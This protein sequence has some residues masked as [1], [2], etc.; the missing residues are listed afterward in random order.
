MIL[1]T[2]WRLLQRPARRGA[3]LWGLLAGLGFW[4]FGLTLVYSVPSG[5]L[6][7]AQGLRRRRPGLGRE[8]LLALGGGLLGASPWL[9]AVAQRGAQPFV[10]ELLGSAIAGASPG[11]WPLG[12][13]SH[14][15]NL[16]LFGPTVVLGMRPPWGTHSLAMPLLPL[17]AILWAFIA[18]HALR[19]LRRPSPP[20]RMQR[21]VLYVAVA[22]LAGYVLTPFGADPSGRYFVPLGLAL[23]VLAADF[24]L[25][26]RL[27]GRLDWL[28]RT[29]PALL[30]AFHLWGALQSALTYPPGLTTQ[31]DPISWIDKRADQELVEFLLA[32]GETRGYSNYW[33]AYPLA[34]LSQERIVF[35]PRLPYHQDFRYSARDNRYAPYDELVRASQRV[36]YITTNHPALE[37]RLRDGFTRLGIRWQEARIG[38]YQIFYRL[39]R[40]VAPEELPV[41]IQVE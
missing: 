5:L 27:P 22:L 15:L 31:F 28:R 26:A 40:P 23:A 37:A 33:V 41:T 8:A 16:L 4:T 19:A 1:L 35:V 25:H 2:T 6:L 12:V 11:S 32:E 38:D 39:S 10:A 21:L 14:S 17:I 30:V 13:A 18:A 7:L 36:A 34:F 20:A 24:S 29:A 9:Y 3:L